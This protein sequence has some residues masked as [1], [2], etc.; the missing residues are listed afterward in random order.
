MRVDGGRCTLAVAR[1]GM[2]VVVGGVAGV[3]VRGARHHGG[4]SDGAAPMAGSPSRAGVARIALVA[5]RRS[6]TSAAPAAIAP[7][8][9]QTVSANCG[10]SDCSRPSTHAMPENLVT[11]QATTAKPLIRRWRQPRRSATYKRDQ[12]DEDLR[13]GDSDEQPRQGRMLGMNSDGGGVDRSGSD[14]GHRLQRCDPP[15]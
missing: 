3:G 1:L 2:A 13:R 8:A 11:S 9:A 7:S 4:D 12:P 6:D 14:R 10:A 5:P 15:R